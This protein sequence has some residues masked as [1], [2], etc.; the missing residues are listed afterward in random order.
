[1]IM[2]P[3]KAGEFSLRSKI[4]RTSPASVGWLYQAPLVYIVGPPLLK[5][6]VEAVENVPLDFL[7]L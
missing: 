6:D 1:M 3:F 2:L 4:L 5:Y 7:C